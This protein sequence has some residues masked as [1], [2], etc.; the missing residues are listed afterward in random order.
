MQ[1]IVLLMLYRGDVSKIFDLQAQAPWI[2]RWICKAQALSTELGG[3]P[4]DIHDLNRADGGPT[5]IGG[6]RV[7]KT[8]APVHLFPAKGGNWD[9]AKIIYVGICIRKKIF[10]P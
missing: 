9:K 5:S 7:F 2:E 10:N 3:Q 1:Q 4:L 6:R 8:H